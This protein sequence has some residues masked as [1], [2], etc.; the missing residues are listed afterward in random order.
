MTGEQMGKMIGTRQ[1]YYIKDGNYKTLTN[2][3]SVSGQLYDNKLNR[4]YN[5]TPM[6]DTL[7]WFDP[8]MDGSPAVSFEIIKNKKNILGNMC[9]ALIVKSAK[10]VTTYYYSA[11]YKLNASLYTKH[12]YGG[13]YY[14]LSK[15]GALPLMTVVDNNQFTMV[16]VAV[17][18]ESMRLKAEDFLVKPGTPVKRSK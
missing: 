13:W 6:S 1:E 15:S 17:G 7:Y 9:D 3:L 4:L 11:K 12:H 2:G 8:S 5:K 10:S 16:S 14:F 18:I